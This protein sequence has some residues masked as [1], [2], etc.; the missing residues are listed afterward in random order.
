MLIGSKKITFEL[1]VLKKWGVLVALQLYVV[2][3]ELKR[4]QKTEAVKIQTD[5]P[6]RYIA[7]L[8]M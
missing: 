1:R 7:S 6:H 4:V 3:L 8:K 5:V 2:F